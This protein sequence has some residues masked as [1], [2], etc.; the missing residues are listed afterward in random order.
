MAVALQTFPMRN[1]VPQYSFNIS[2]SGT[3][4]NIQVLFNVRMQRYIMNINDTQGN[5]ILAGIPV[6]IE[7]NLTGQYITL[8]IPSGTFF[9]TDDTGQDT[10]PTQFSFG[11][12]HTM[13]YVG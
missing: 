10:Q 11:L 4:F 8:A 2:L 12:D 9:C 3:V 1:D 7:R 6:L 5:T 13:F